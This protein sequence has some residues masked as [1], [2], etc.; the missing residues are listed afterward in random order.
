MKKEIW[1]VIKD[2]ED[3]EVSNYGVI[4]RIRY[5]ND[6]YKHKNELPYYIKPRLDKD[7]YVR[8]TLCKNGK[9]KQVFAHR[10][11]CQTFIPNPNNYPVINHKDCNTQ[12]NYVDN[13][14][15]CTIKYNNNY[16]EKMGR[17][18]ICYGEKHPNSK[19]VLM[20]D[21]KNNFIREF[22]SS[23]EASR[24]TGY[25][26]TKIR[27]CCNPKTKYNKYKDYIF[28]YKENQ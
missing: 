21:K 1:K 16:I 25:P 15:W 20:Y 24:Y 10:I 18:N 27:Y 28:Q 22:A 13:L 14:E 23:G 4:R 3:Y 11:V 19:V 9:M 17:R 2:F 6:M 7:G 26:S 12:N 8:Y 5:S